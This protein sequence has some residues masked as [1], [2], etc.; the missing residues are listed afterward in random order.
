MDYS[1]E[2]VLDPANDDSGDNVGDDA[3]DRIYSPFSN[4]CDSDV[5]VGDDPDDK[6]YMYNE[7]KTPT[8]SAAP[9]DDSHDEMTVQ[10]QLTK[11]QFAQLTKF[12]PFLLTLLNELQAD[13]N[14]RWTADSG[15]FDLVVSKGR[16]YIEYDGDRT[17]VQSFSR[18]LR[19][20]NVK[21][22]NGCYRNPLF[23]RDQLDLL[24]QIKR[25]DTNHWIPA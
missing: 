11:V 21:T 25:K 24:A 10:L 12:Q 8:V 18:Q 9:G 13:S 14:V 16:E 1:L 5:P 2:K 7:A 22:K 17:K 20:F 23:H 19:N 15:S 4:D 6:M 3:D